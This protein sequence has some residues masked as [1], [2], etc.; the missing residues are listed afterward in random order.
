VA[1]SQETL[2]YQDKTWVPLW[3]C[4]PSLLGFLTFLFAFPIDR[5]VPFW[6]H[7]SLAETF[8]LWFLFIA[9]IATAIAIVTQVK[10]KRAGIALLAKLLVWTAIAIS[11]VV[12]AFVLVGM[13]ASMY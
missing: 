2:Q 9:P 7:L 8:T 5:R 13:W 1:S 10:R 12:N 3:W 6:P 11:L 4:L